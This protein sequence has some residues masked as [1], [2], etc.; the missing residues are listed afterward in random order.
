MRCMAWPLRGP[1]KLAGGASG[2]CGWASGR[3][4][5]RRGRMGSRGDVVS[6]PTGAG[7][8]GGCEVG[9]QVPVPLEGAR[10]DSHCGTVV[11]VGEAAH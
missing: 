7:T 10:L 5:D 11:G 9:Q 1:D 2:T 8:S 6:R 4:V 3:W